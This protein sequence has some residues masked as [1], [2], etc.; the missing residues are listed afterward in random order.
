MNQ[1]GRV[2]ADEV[3]HLR[4]R[5]RWTAEI[6]VLVPAQVVAPADQTVIALEPHDPDA[7]S[8]GRGTVHGASDAVVVKR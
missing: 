1:L 5:R 7:L 4:A 3:I 2:A 6:P 8:V